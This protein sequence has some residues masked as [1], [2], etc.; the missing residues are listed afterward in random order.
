MSEPDKTKIEALRAEIARLY[1]K[2][3][4]RV[5]VRIQDASHLF[6]EDKLC[7]GS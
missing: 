5:V 7:G 6:P 4:K 1:L 3:G 2:D